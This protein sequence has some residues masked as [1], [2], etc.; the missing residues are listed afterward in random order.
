VTF[1]CVGS[2]GHMLSNSRALSLYAEGARDEYTSAWF[3]DRVGMAAA[4]ARRMAAV[5]KI[6]NPAAAAA[7]AGSAPGAFSAA[8]GENSHRC[9][10]LH[11]PAFVV[12]AH[13]HASCHGLT[14]LS[15]L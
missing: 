10:H 13:A 14:V 6:L 15:D 8:P 1:P 5:I 3:V 4:H 12:A 2:Y 11:P 7:G 9:M